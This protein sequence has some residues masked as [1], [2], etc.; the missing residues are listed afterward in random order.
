MMITQ[1]YAVSSKEK[2]LHC[3]KKSKANYTSILQILNRA[4]VSTHHVL[5]DEPN[6]ECGGGNLVGEDLEEEQLAGVM[7]LLKETS[8]LISSHR[9]AS[10]LHSGCL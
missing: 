3:S 2:S 8:W 4:A 1:F 10:L 7:L 6:R 9:S 5:F